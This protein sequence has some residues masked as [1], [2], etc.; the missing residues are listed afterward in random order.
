MH[1]QT[2][3]VAG[4]GL[5]G[6]SIAAAVRAVSPGI[7]VVG[8]GRNPE[9]LQQALQKGLIT[10]WVQEIS[11]SSIPKDSLGVVCLP[12]D[13]IPQMAVALLRAGCSA[14]TDAGSTKQT[15][16]E[17]LR[18]EQQFVGAHPIAGSE[19]A[20]FEHADAQL[21]QGRVCV[22]CPSGASA[23]A[24]QRVSGFWSSLGLIVKEL[25]PAEHDWILALTSHLPHVLAAVAAGVVTDEQLV[26][27]GSGFR[28]TTRIAAGSADV[29]TSIL[30]QNSSAC[31]AA[32]EQ[33]TGLLERFREVIRDGDSA[34]LRSLWEASAER[35][36]K[37]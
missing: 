12:V 9:R 31:V 3:V 21:F 7:R 28:D 10:D 18:G 1:E 36:R 15:I 23:E 8:V 30:M 27:T 35:R 14:V 6:G 5:I 37:L 2:I 22:L 25:E 11:V 34:A 4:V 19:Q 24:L 16:C 26:F 32:I 20:G 29:W 13:Q 17:R 33:A